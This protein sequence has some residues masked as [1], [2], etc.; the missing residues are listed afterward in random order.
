MFQYTLIIFL[1]LLLLEFYVL[2]TFFM[3]CQFPIEK[4]KIRKRT[5]RQRKGKVTGVLRAFGHSGQ[6][7]KAHT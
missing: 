6:D 4:F 1:F 3:T 2:V 7:L 5:G